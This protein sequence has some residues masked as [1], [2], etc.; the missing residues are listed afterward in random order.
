MDKEADAQCI[1]LLRKVESMRKE[2]RTLETELS[3]ACSEY[4]KRRG[5]SLFRE[6][7]VNN[8]H[9]LEQRQELNRL[10]EEA[11]DRDAWEKSNA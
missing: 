7:H 5:M 2:L 3:Q 9:E 10:M 8:Q 1:A 4:G 11:A 6:W